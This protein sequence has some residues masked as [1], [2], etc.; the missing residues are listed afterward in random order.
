MSAIL[1][2]EGN[3][4]LIAPFVAKLSN[5]AQGRILKAAGEVLER[6]RWWLPDDDK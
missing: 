5:F 1:S 3:I 6:S 2:Q 4:C